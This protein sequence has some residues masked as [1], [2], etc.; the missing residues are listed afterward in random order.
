[1]KKV[2]NNNDNLFATREFI[3]TDRLRRTRLQIFA[4]SCSFAQ[5]A[6]ASLRGCFFV[7]LGALHALL[8]DRRRRRRKYLQ[9]LRITL[10][11]SGHLKTD[12][13]HEKSLTDAMN[14]LIDNLRTQQPVLRIIV[15]LF[16]Q[17]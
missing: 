15:R 5:R 4:A 7:R 17:W 16:V 13:C 9:L 14:R 6:N 11:M 2:N 10:A 1:M 12:G 8:R 3:F